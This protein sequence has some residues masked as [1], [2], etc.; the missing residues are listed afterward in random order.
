LSGNHPPRVTTVF[1]EARGWLSQNQAIAARQ[2]PAVTGN[3]LVTKLQ[4]ELANDPL[5]LVKEV[6]FGVLAD[7]KTTEVD[8]P[9][10]GQL[11][12]L[13]ANVQR[14]SWWAV[15]LGEKKA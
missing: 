4:V 3:G 2:L 8:V 5:K 6:R 1:Y 9:V 12:T 10:T 7:G 13:P 15:L 11:V 14:L